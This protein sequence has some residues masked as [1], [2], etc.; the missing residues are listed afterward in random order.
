MQDSRS[1][2]LSIQGKISIPKDAECRTLS[3]YGVKTLNMYGRSLRRFRRPKKITWLPRKPWEKTGK[4]CTELFIRQ[5]AG[6]NQVPWV[7]ARISFFLLVHNSKHGTAFHHAWAITEFLG[8]G[9]RTEEGRCCSLAKWQ[10]DK[11]FLWQLQWPWQT[12]VSYDIS[13][14]DAFNNYSHKETLPWQKKK[15][16]QQW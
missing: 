11:W 10:R 1:T 16:S 5:C 7:S 12:L 15:S 4:R 2:Y 13:E 14:E 3:D 6:S 9:C 8:S